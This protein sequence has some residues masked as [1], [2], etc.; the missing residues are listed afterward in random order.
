[1][2]FDGDTTDSVRRL[3]DPMAC[4]ETTNGDP[5]P[6]VWA[7]TVDEIPVSITRLPS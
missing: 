4:A 7:K 3:T 6:F 5:E 1:M 2:H